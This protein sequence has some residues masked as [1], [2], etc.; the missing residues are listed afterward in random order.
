MAI[1][2][3]EEAVNSREGTQSILTLD[4]DTQL[5][6]L[7][8]SNT[9]NI[10]TQEVEVITAVI[11]NAP[12]EYLTLPMAPPRRR[13]IGSGW[14]EV[15]VPY[16]AKEAEANKRSEPQQSG[17]MTGFSFSFS[18]RGT[19]QRIRQSVQLVA[20]YGSA[21]TTSVVGKSDP[22]G[23]D[24]QRVNGVDIIIPQATFSETHKFEYNEVDNDQ[25]FAWLRLIGKT[26]AAK[27]R[28]AEIGE[29][30][31]T[32]ITGQQSGSEPWDI[33]FEFLFQENGSQT[34]TIFPKGGGASSDTAVSYQGHHVIDFGYEDA[35]SANERINNLVWVKVHQVYK[36][37]DY[38]Q[39]G[40]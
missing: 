10:E 37:G 9:A 17:G 4:G 27:F 11:D 39:L 30:L 18:F 14:W 22:I 33:T 13:E 26:N 29:L 16:S 1:T 23:Y 40:I 25:K 32:S 6:Y 19:T 8:H 12:A 3:F 5:T 21:P 7:V 36:S 31:L 34:F 15:T 24:G 2:A 35:V 38:S 20:K 28:N